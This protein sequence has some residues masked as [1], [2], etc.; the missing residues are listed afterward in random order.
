[1]REHIT[2]PGSA[3]LSRRAG[4]QVSQPETAT[5]SGIEVHEERLCKVT[6]Q[7][8]YKM[9]CECGRLWVAVQLPKF[10]KCPAC[11]KL[12]IVFK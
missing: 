8:L 12:G 4:L 5:D 10:V 7:R 2:N 3:S 1:V 11:H 6:V 9:R